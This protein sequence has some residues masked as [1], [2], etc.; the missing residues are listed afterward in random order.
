[1]RLVADDD[2]DRRRADQAVGLD[3]PARLREHVILH[4]RFELVLVRLLEIRQLG[5][6][7]A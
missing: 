2:I 5:M 7:L 6:H 4:R 1:V 3:V